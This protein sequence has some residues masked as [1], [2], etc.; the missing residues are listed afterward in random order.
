M[1]PE[2]ISMQGAEIEGSPPEVVFP[3]REKVFR[4][5]RFSM[6]S[7]K[8]R[9]ARTGVYIF[10]HE[11]AGRAL[12]KLCQ[13]SALPPGVY[14][15]RMLA[16]PEGI[17][18]QGAEIEGSPPGGVL[19]RTSRTRDPSIQAHGAKLTRPPQR[20]RDTG[21]SGPAPSSLQSPGQCSCSARP[22]RMRPS[23]GC[24]LRR[25]V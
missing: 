18:M 1:R 4:P 19:F 22:D 23:R 11:D 10:V 25:P 21:E 3:A 8:S 5:R 14:L 20:L 12:T 2:G 15:Q 24:R 17:S 16:R 13:K 6:Q 7:A 9:S